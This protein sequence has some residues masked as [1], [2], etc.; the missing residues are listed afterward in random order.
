MKYAPAR[1]QNEDAFLFWPEETLSE[2]DWAIMLDHAIRVAGSDT[3]V[4]DLS[5]YGQCFLISGREI[6]QQTVGQIDP[7]ATRAELST[8]PVAKHPVEGKIEIAWSVRDE[9]EV[10]PAHRYNLEISVDPPTNPALSHELSC[11]A[12]E[13]LFR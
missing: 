5:A 1:F 10:D 4:S 12:T 11:A 3:D 13:Q 9:L 2:R 7:S 6:L 8:S